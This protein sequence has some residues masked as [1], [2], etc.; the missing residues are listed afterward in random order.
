[1]DKL[2]LTISGTPIDAPAGIPTGGIEAGGKA[3]NLGFNLLFLVGVII[4]VALIMYSGI[5][6]TLSNGEKEKIASARARITYSII[7]LV[8][9]ITAFII[10]KVVLSILGYNPDFFFNL[11]GSN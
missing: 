9:I 5:Q 10:V 3:I 1:M 7:G 2:V 6:W 11:I 8:V 4:T